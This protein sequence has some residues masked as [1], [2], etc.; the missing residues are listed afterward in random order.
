VR[1][2]IDTSALVRVI[3][4]QVDPHWDEQTG[5]GV[6]AVCEPVL[7]ETLTIAG[8][9]HYDQLEDELLNTY[10]WVPVP[11]RAWDSARAVRRALAAQSTHQGL[12]V[13]DHLVVATARHHGLT[14]LH[15]DA[16]FETV[17]RIVPDF[18]QERISR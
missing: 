5:H 9:K 10:P 7:I 4:R 2:L 1:Y 17:G 18:R 11:E 3:R 6:V 12:S 15:D 8:A 16:D 14:V 13:A